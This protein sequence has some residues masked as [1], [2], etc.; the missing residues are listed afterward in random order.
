MTHD[1]SVRH[2]FNTIGVEQTVQHD[3]RCQGDSF[4]ESIVFVGK[5]VKSTTMIRHVKFLDMLNHI[6]F[7][8]FKK[9]PSKDDLKCQRGSYVEGIVFALGG[10]G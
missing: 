5:G 7:C 4:A 6:W 10:R 3:S 1:A 8:R 2:L 9:L